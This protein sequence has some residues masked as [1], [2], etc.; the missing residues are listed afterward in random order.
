MT[1]V[2][3]ML[4]TSFCAVPA[5]SRVEPR[6][7]SSPTAGSMEKPG[8]VL[9]GRRAR[10]GDGEGRRPEAARLPEDPEAPRSP[11]ARAHGDHGVTAR[12]AAGADLRGAVRLVVLG[13]LD[14][15]RQR[16]GAAGDVALHEVGRRRRTSGGTRMR[17]GP[18][19]ARSCRR[20][21]RGAGR[22]RAAWPRSRR[23]S[24]RPSAPP[25]GPPP[26]ARGDPRRS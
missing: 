5:A 14:R 18:P 23:R 4:S 12:D 17:R 22:P 9:H 3:I 8:R 13:P 25:R 20:R 6:R 1:P 15:L 7:T 24:A 16:A 2:E 10:A 19:V 26:T 11:A 21:T